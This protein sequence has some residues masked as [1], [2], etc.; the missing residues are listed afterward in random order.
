MKKEL[1]TKEYTGKIIDI[2]AHIAYR[3]LYSQTFLAE[4]TKEF[5]IKGLLKKYVNSMLDKVLSDFEGDRLI[6]QMD[7]AGIGKSVLLCTDFDFKKNDT[8]YS[9]REMH[10]LCLDQMRKHSDRFIAFAGVSP[11]RAADDYGI[12]AEYIEKYGFKGIKLYPPIGF[13]L[14][15]DKLQKYYELCNAYNLSVLIHTGPSVKGFLQISNYQKDVCFLANTY[16]KAKFV[17][18]HAAIKDH[19]TGIRIASTCENVFLD[20]SSYQNESQDNM[21]LKEKLDESLETVPQKVIFGT[22]WPM[23]NFFVSQKSWVSLLEEILP[24]D[25]ELRASLF[26]KNAK[27]ILENTLR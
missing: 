12:A 6:Q 4:V 17:L 14:T 5:L 10:Q 13:E 21:A 3:Q 26:Y 19:K 9:V 7:E 25:E 23:Y 15:D 8:P 22:D 20:I 18:A 24:E 1:R 27:Y 11:F 16:K 2:H